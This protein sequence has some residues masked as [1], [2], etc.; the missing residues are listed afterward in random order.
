M[1]VQ[2]YSPNWRQFFLWNAVGT[3][4][5][6][7]VIGPTL[8]AIDVLQFMRWNYVFAFILMYITATLMRGA[9]HLVVQVQEKAREN[10]VSPLESVLAQPALKPEDDKDSDD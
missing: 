7:F 8:V 6:S 5:L 9:F 4:F 2:Q 3:G 1:L 10:K